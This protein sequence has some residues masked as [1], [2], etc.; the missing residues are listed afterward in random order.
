MIDPR[1]TPARGDV[2]AAKLKG[3]VEAKR[4]ADGM[5]QQ[6]RVGASVLRE[7][8]S[9]SARL[10][11]QL[12]YGELFDVYDVDADGWAWGQ[13]HLDAYVGYARADSLDADLLESPTHRVAVL[14]TLVFPEPDKKSQPPSPLSLN[15]KLTVKAPL[16]NGFAPLSRGGWVYAAHLALIDHVVSDWVAS[17]ERFV[18]LPYLWGG[19]DSS[20]VDCSGL[21][22]TSLETGGVSAPRDADMQEQSVGQAIAPNATLQ[23]GDLA[24][25]PGHVGII[26][27]PTELLHANAFHMQTVIEPLAAAVARLGAPRTIRRISAA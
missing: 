13:A 16:Q 15:A 17:A 4:F 12:L 7:A 11:T 9:F 14:R 27:S 1:L 5:V 19:K 6:V 20:A 8:P 23:R 3:Q 26:R 10:E 21:V 25:W 22:Q 24:F 18:G 2:A